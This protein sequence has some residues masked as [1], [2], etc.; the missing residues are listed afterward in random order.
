MLLGWKNRTPRKIIDNLNAVIMSNLTMQ[1][2]KHDLSNRY[3]NSF[4]AAALS[5]KYKRCSTTSYQTF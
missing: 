4:K 5:T 3:K 1:Q 2:H